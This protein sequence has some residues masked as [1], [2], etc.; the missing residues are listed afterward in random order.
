MA[1][2]VDESHMEVF[3]KNMVIQHHSSA[4]VLAHKW[5]SEGSHSH[6]SAY[7]ILQS[8]NFKSENLKKSQSLSY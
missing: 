4:P 6:Y 2:S 5:V 7:D 8:D 1:F 3:E